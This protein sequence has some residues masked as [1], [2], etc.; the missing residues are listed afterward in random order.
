MDQD[1]FHRLLG[2]AAAE[3]LVRAREQSLGEQ[4]P[5]IGGPETI[6]TV[7]GVDYVNDGGSTHLDATLRSMADIDKPIIWIAGNLSGGIGQGHVREFL[8]ERIVALVLYG[9]A[10]ERGIESL[11][12]FTEHMYTAEELRTAVFVARE[13][14]RTGEA[15][16]F[17]PACPCG[18]THTDQEARG[19]EFKQA[20]QDL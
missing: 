8:R 18:T 6:A 11:T 10:G 5:V 15:V 16:L 20:V 1:T 19:T 14:A 12:P 17:S 4:R 9:K 2:K 3:R 7:N 13:L